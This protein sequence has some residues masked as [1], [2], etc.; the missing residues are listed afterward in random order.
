MHSLLL[1]IWS[2]LLVI[3]PYLIFGF[4]FA[5]LLSIL[6]SQDLIEKNLGNDQGILSIHYYYLRKVFYQ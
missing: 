5:G 2:I 3:S 4:L 6:I 1:E